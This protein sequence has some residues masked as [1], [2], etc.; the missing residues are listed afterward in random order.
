[1]EGVEVQKEEETLGWAKSKEYWF[2]DTQAFS[3][4][5]EKVVVSLVSFFLV[6]LFLRCPSQPSADPLRLV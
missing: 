1:M 2:P 5:G 6:S 4:K 3:R